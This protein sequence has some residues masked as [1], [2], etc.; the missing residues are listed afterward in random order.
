MKA[1]KN[2]GMLSLPLSL[3]GI[4]FDIDMTHWHNTSPD[5]FFHTWPLEFC[6]WVYSSR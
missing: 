4:V 3:T 5:G 1:D 6:E 2:G